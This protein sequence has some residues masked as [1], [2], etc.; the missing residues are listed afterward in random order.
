MI[1]WYHFFYMSLLLPRTMSVPTYVR[2]CC[3]R[4]CTN[5]SKVTSWPALVIGMLTRS[6]TGLGR[7][8]GVDHVPF[9]PSQPDYIILNT[10]IQPAIWNKGAGSE[11]GY[12]VYPIVDY[13]RVWQKKT[14]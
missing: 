10:A 12:P 11:G 9:I 8:L 6:C 3:A 14:A 5:L 4:L 1:R 2:F 7:E 13:V